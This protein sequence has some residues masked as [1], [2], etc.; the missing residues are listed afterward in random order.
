MA[1]EELQRALDAQS[2]SITQ[3]TREREILVK[4][5]SDASAALSNLHWYVHFVRASRL[6]I[7]LTS[8]LVPCSTARR[9]IHLIKHGTT[10][11]YREK[12]QV[13]EVVRG[14][15]RELEERDSDLKVTQVEIVRLQ[16][17]L[18]SS[19]VSLERSI[20]QR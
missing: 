12:R 20:R 16:S 3:L 2:A 8:D 17:Q 11:A 4:S 18:V 14:I 1:M 6:L 10:H 13:E 9:C 5:G 7:N 15:K 19:D